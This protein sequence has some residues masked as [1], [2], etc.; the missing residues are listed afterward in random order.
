MK[1]F[2]TKMTP[3]SEDLP[4][5]SG[6]A[7]AYIRGFADITWLQLAAIENL[8]SDNIRARKYLDVVKPVKVIYLFE[9]ICHKLGDGRM[10]WKGLD[11][12]RKSL[13]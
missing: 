5:L 9:A 1:K 7:Y 6:E 2:N 4:E 11:E 13:V 3:K 10:F 12:F 8:R